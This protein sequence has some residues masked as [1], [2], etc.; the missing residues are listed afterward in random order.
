MTYC[1]LIPRPQS[2]RHMLYPYSQAR[3]FFLA[4]NE[5]LLMIRLNLNT[6]LLKCKTFTCNRSQKYLCLNSISLFYS[7]CRL[8]TRWKV[9][10]YL[11]RFRKYVSNGFPIII[12]CNPG[13]HY[14]TPCIYSRVCNAPI[15]LA[16]RSK[17][18]VYAHSLAVVAVS[19]P[20]GVIDVLCHACV[21]CCQL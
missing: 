1:N 12:F 5:F 17:A 19:N 15:P 20:D 6:Q 16:A 10:F 3:T 2:L 8:H 18:W 9:F 11:Y 7:S 14:E 21:V 4:C 13:V